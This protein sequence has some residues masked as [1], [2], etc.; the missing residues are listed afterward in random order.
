MLRIRCSGPLNMT[1]Q[2]TVNSENSPTNCNHFAIGMVIV[3]EIMFPRLS[4][5][6]VDEKLLELFIARARA[7]RSHNVE[8]QIATKTWTQLSITCQP[9]LVA[10]LAE[11]HVRHCTDK[12]Y[13]LCA[14]RNLVVRGWTIR[15]KLRLR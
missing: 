8:L 13:A 6:H 11:M 10:V 1:V 3:S 7:Q 15:S 9:Q 12:T 5:D 4:V 2:K 14:S